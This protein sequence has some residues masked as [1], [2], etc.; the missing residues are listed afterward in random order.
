MSARLS[1]RGV[2]KSSG[3]AEIARDVDS[4]AAENFITVLLLSSTLSMESLMKLLFG[5][6]DVT[7]K[8]ENTPMRTKTRIFRPGVKFCVSVFRQSQEYR[9]KNVSA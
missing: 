2:A 7:T 3:S 5:N 8:N 1:A 9:W 4:V 6:H